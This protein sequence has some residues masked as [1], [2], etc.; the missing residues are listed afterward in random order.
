MGVNQQLMNE[1]R[2][3][4][5]LSFLCMRKSEE[6]SHDDSGLF[7]VSWQ[8]LVQEIIARN[9]KNDFRIIFSCDGNDE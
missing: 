1:A 6:M 9:N 7:L 4:M 5:N 3:A 8:V 2:I